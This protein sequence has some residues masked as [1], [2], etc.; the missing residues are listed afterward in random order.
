M[1][2]KNNFEGESMGITT[3]IFNDD[4]F[5]LDG[6][7]Y[8]RDT[9]SGRYY[10]LDES[11]SLRREMDGALVR[12]R[13]SKQVYVERFQECKMKIA[14][15]EAFRHYVQEEIDYDTYQSIVNEIHKD[16]KAQF[17]ELREV[18]AAKP[19]ALKVVNKETDQLIRESKVETD[20]QMKELRKSMGEVSNRFGE[21]AEHLVIPHIVEKFNALRYHFE[22]IGKNMGILPL[23]VDIDLFV[24]QIIPH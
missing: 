23:L 13:I 4:M 17:E 12:R 11:V 18:E 8:E 9:Y 16:K 14:E 6:I 7:N 2:V 21:L 24:N 22:D 20:Q 10:R 15:K 3:M 5:E 19:A 1:R